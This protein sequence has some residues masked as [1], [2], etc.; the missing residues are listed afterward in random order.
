MHIVG[1]TQQINQTLLQQAGNPRKF[2]EAQMRAYFSKST[3]KIKLLLLMLALG[4]GCFTAGDLWFPQ[5]QWHIA[6][7]VVFLMIALCFW[8]L[9]EY[10]IKV[11]TDAEYDAWVYN[12]AWE[13][14]KRAWRKVDEEGLIEHNAEPIFSIHGFVLAGTKQAKKYRAKDLLWKTGKDKAKRYSINVY[15]FFIPMEHQLAVF[16]FDI[17][18]VNHRDHRSLVQQ[19]FFA[20]VVGITT[21]DELE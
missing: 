13:L 21:D 18:A 19:Y 6:A 10:G 1:K 16:A 12:K 20:D 11:P 14:F 4:I 2:T 15:T 8:M 3:F 17:N 7:G 5:D 9:I